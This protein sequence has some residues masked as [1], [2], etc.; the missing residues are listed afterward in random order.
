MR[1]LFT[2]FLILFFSTTHGVVDSSHLSSVN[3][4][5][6]ADIQD[7]KSSQTQK[8]RI[9]TSM[10]HTNDCI[11]NG[12]GTGHSA[13]SCSMDHKIYTSLIASNSPSHENIKWYSLFD[14]S[15]QEHSNHLHRP[16]II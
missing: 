2:A 5:I 6:A 10:L 9:V 16:P 7:I 3:L 15:S 4:H 13:S 1:I 8:H 12:S 11:Q 14:A